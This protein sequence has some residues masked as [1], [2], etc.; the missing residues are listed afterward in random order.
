M[1]RTNNNELKYAYLEHFEFGL[2]MEDVVSCAEPMA[3]NTDACTEVA[4]KDYVR[5]QLDRLT[6]KE[7][8]WA[9][10]ATGIEGTER[11]TRNE[12]YIKIV[13]IAAWDIVD[14]EE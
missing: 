4:E 5:E 13:W 9:V 6:E 14:C 12:L 7:L 1:E 8:R 3:D 10:K 11:M 2:T